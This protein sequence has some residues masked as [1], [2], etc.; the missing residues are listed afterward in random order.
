[1][2]KVSALESI[3]GEF[4]LSEEEMIE[5][6][7]RWCQIIDGI[8]LQDKDIANITATYTLHMYMQMFSTKPLSTTFHKH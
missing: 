2:Q 3:T 7:Y 5:F 8:L 4:W 1:M 6:L